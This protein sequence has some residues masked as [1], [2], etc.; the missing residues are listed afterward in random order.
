V[1]ETLVPVDTIDHFCDE[2]AIEHIDLL[3]SDTQGYECQVFQGAERMLS[4]GRIDLVYFEVIFS[5][6]YRGRPFGDACNL[7]L[8]HGYRLVS[9]YEMFRQNGL[10]S[11]TDALFVH[12]NRLT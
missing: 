6:Q 12:P 10:L 2:H 4:E 7:L 9:F 3:K 11:W 1:C 5:D 8:R